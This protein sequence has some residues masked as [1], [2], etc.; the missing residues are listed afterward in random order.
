MAKVFYPIKLY[1]RNPGVSV[2]LGISLAL[3][4]GSWVW[5]L[6][7]I[8]PREELIFLHYNILFGV[9]LIGPWYQILYIP[10][11]GLGILLVNALLGWILFNRDKFAA[12]LLLA[13]SVICQVFLLIGSAILVFLNV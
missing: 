4:L 5:L 6:W 3:N 10:I 2:M 9:D 1:F 13:G 12:H 11:F 8:G 7:Q